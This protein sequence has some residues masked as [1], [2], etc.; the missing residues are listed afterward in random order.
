M[1]HVRA[2]HAHGVAVYSSTTRGTISYSSG[3]LHQVPHAAVYSSADS[4]AVS[5]GSMATMALRD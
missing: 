3:W 1:T 2:L 5:T 4:G